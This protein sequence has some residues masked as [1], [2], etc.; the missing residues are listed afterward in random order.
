[1][2]L[3]PRDVP[4]ERH[5]IQLAADSV[6]LPDDGGLRAFSD[7]RTLPGPIRERDFKQDAGEEIA[8]L[9]NYASWQ[10]QALYPGYLAGESKA[11]DEFARYLDVLA[12]TV[13]AWR[14]L[15]SD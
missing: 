10:L 3:R 11:C 14:R 5:L 15:L 2:S 4:L 13:Q 12:L 7:A 8:D 1:M 9:A 6:G